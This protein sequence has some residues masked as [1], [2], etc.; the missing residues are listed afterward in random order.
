MLNSRDL[1]R[2]CVRHEALSFSDGGERPSISPPSRRPG[3]SWR[4]PDPGVAGEGLSKPEI[5][6]CLKRYVAREACH[7]LPAVR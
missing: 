3:G 6:R 4:Q 1:I 7:H 2:A 5:I